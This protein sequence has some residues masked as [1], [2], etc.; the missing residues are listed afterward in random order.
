MMVMI[1]CFIFCDSDDDNRE[2][3]QVVS[4]QHGSPRKRQRTV[5][6]YISIFD[7]FWLKSNLKNP[8]FNGIRT[9]QL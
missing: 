1:G 8:I 3:P 2:A 7:K 9:F 6:V 4:P 5:Y